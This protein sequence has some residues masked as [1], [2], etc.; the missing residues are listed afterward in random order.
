[1]QV[2]LIETNVHWWFDLTGSVCAGPLRYLCELQGVEAALHAVQSVVMLLP[3]V[4]LVPVWAAGSRGGLACGSKRGDAAA[5]GYCCPDG[6]SGLRTAQPSLHPAMTASCARYSASCLL[7]SH[8]QRLYISKP[9]VLIGW[10]ER[11][12]GKSGSAGHAGH[13]FFI[14]FWQQ[15]FTDLELPFNI[16]YIC[17]SWHGFVLYNAS[18]IGPVFDGLT[19]YS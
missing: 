17:I 19:H 18:F 9:Y 13:A 3:E 15:L 6:W 10:R 1:M 4:N 16:L 8:S 11:P 5:R 14:P 12:D 2:K 7:Q